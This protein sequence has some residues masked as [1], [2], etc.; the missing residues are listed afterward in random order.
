MDWRSFLR[1]ATTAAAGAAAGKDMRFS[2]CLKCFTLNAGVFHRHRMAQ[3]GNGC[4]LSCN[5]FCSLCLRTACI[6]CLAGDQLT[7]GWSNKQKCI[8]CSL[9]AFAALSLSPGIGLPAVT[10]DSGACFDI[11]DS[12]VRQAVGGRAVVNVR[13]GAGK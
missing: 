1:D 8:L 11:I 2:Q 12:T 5:N 13:C 7:P 6:L 4:P 3:L 10:S 9:R